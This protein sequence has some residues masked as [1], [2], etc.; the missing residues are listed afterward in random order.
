MRIALVIAGLFAIA[1]VHNLIVAGGLSMNAAADAAASFACLQLPQ[2]IVRLSKSAA[3]E[4][5]RVIAA[6]G[7][8]P[9]TAVRLV[10][11]EPTVGDY[12]I[13]YDLPVNDARDWQIKSE[14]LTVLVEKSALEKWELSEIVVDFKDGQFTFDRSWV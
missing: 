8:S 7:F 9:E 13:E 14:G 3:D 5:R 1:A 12:A 11:L 2:N 4:A 10:V 6:G